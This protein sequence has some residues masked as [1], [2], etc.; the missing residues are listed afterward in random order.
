MQTSGRQIFIDKEIVYPGEVVK[1]EIKIIATEFFQNRLEEGMNF[2][3]R[4]GHKIIGTGQI[5][6][7]VNET[8]K[9]SSTE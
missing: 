8:L 9:K 5:I 1:A 4:E 2:D 7:I 3:F 6:K